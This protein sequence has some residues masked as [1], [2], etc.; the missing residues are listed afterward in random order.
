MPAALPPLAL[1]LLAGLP[2]SSARVQCYQGSVQYFTDV[3][4]CLEVDFHAREPF[5]ELSLLASDEHGRH[6]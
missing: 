3:H 6:A 5:E 2:C 4:S 1:L